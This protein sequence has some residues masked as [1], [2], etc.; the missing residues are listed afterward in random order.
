MCTEKIQ[1]EIEGEIVEGEIADQHVVNTGR[2]VLNQGEIV[3][4][5][6]QYKEFYYLCLFVLIILREFFKD[7][8][9]DGY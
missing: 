2:K 1:H 7:V 8:V 6:Q 5:L 3:N 9:M 4:C